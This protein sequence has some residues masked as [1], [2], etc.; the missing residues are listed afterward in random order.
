MSFQFHYA[1]PPEEMVRS[2]QIA[3]YALYT[4]M[5][6]IPKVWLGTLISGLGSGLLAFHVLSHAQGE[7][8]LLSMLIDLPSAVAIGALA[9]GLASFISQTIWRQLVKHVR[10][11]ISLEK[12]GR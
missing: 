9:G 6:A 5:L 12:R 3:T 7:L 8:A 10:P 1:P 4:A 11:T 2:G